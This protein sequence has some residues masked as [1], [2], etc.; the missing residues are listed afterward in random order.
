MFRNYLL[1]AFRN[2]IKFR[3]YALINLLGLSIGIASAWIIFL[4]LTFEF[5]YDSFHPKSEDIYYMD[6]RMEIGDNEMIFVNT[7]LP[8]HEIIETNLPEVDLSVPCINKGAKMYAADN[9]QFIANERRILYT[10]E[11]FLELFQFPLIQGDKGALNSPFALLVTESLAKKYYGNT[12]VMGKTMYVSLNDSAQAFTIQ[13]ILKDLPPNSNF[14]FQVLASLATLNPESPDI[15][16]GSFSSATYLSIPEGANL[17]TL[18]NKL[19]RLTKEV[20]NKSYWVEN[21]SFKF[22][23]NPILEKH[24]GGGSLSSNSQKRT[25]LS[26]GIVAILILLMASINYLNLSTARATMREQE[27]GIRKVLG[28][29]RY[30]LSWQFFFEALCY[31]LLA[32]IL[33]VLLADLALPYFFTILGKSFTPNLWSKPITWLSVILLGFGTGILAGVYPALHLSGLGN[34][35]ERFQR[36]REKTL[37]RKILATFQFTVAT[38]LITGVIIVSEQIRFMQEVDLGF[39]KEHLMYVQLGSNPTHEKALVLKNELEKLP[40]VEVASLGSGTMDGASGGRTINISPTREE[41]VQT[42]NVDEALDE[43]MGFEMVLGKWFEGNSDRGSYL[44]NEAFVK[45]FELEDP[46]GTPLD[47]EHSS[48]KIIG[49]VQDFYFGSLAYSINPLVIQHVDSSYIN[50]VALKLT[51]G[52]PVQALAAIQETWYR[53]FPAE[54]FEYDFL[55]EKLIQIYEDERRFAQ[56]IGIF[57]GLA[58]LISCLGL[59]ALIAFTASRRSKEVGIRKILGAS[60]RDIAILLNKSFFALIGISFLIAI[61]LSWWLGNQWLES[62]ANRIELGPVFFLVAILTVLLIAVLTVSYFTFKAA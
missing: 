24:L 30:Q 29:K 38:L 1:I 6:T 22:A 49:V 61:P 40:Q 20:A 47:Y 26:F 11:A 59:L 36:K 58:I 7:P 5:S 43:A 32:A 27:I 9:P 3:G 41:M 31:S 4:Y 25:L 19:V 60:V 39:E 55:D 53:V 13:G 35:A 14:Q 2:F 8:L 15:G 37:L 56:I 16:W 45:E 50:H 54:V 10:R 18:S 34:I 23:F 46:L 51:G 42:I 57:T 17:D 28:A 44:V 21:S 62:Y 52:D 12:Q 33:G 48:G